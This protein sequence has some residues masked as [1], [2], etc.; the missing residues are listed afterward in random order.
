MAKFNVIWDWC[1]LF[2]IACFGTESV[3]FIMFL[4][5]YFCIFFGFMHNNKLLENLIRH[6]LKNKS[7][8]EKAYNNNL[9]NGII[10]KK[11]FK[12]LTISDSHNLRVTGSICLYIIGQNWLIKP[13]KIWSE[14]VNNKTNRKLWR[15]FLCLYSYSCL[16]LG[17]FRKQQFS[18]HQQLGPYQSW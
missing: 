15:I 6:F 8:N 4:V 2:V 11:L 10:L 3:V 1:V 9:L 5:L 14:R 17:R 16:G 18:C 12:S 13:R 7:R